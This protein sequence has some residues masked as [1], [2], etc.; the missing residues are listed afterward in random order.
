[1]SFQNK[2]NHN[3]QVICV[4]GHPIK[5]SLSP[6]MHNISFELKGLNYLYLPFDV[7]PGYLKDALRGIL[8]LSIK[9]LNITIPHKASIV[10]YLDLVSEEASII[11]AVNTVV[12]EGGVLKGYNTDVNGIIASLKDYK[13]DIANA[14]VSVIGAGGAA[15]SVIYSMIR[16]FKVKKIN[17]INR[18]VQ[19]AESLREYFTTRLHFE[20]IFAHELTPPDLVDVL[21]ESALIIN[22]TSIGMSPET[23]DAAT[24]IAD[25]F[26]KDQI[27]FDVV[28]NPVKTKMLEIAKSKGAKIVDGLTMFVEQGAKSFEL[29]TGE[30]MDNQKIY[31]T[32]QTYLE[33]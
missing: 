3:T 10:E 13:D 17:I 12:N 6:L 16:N 9:G 15:R 20:S 2:F 23:D 24:I 14:T 1:M 8:A 18:T 7:T 31:K 27:V 29:W 22:T 19:K 28:Y 32:L 11:G 26:I 25:S 33:T 4:I 30:K 5:H 21:N